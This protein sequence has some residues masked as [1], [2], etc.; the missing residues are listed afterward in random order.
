MYDES[1]DR[2]VIYYTS[3]DNGTLGM[4]DVEDCGFALFYEDETCQHRVMAENLNEP[5]ALAI[6][7]ERG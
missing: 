7:Q 5:R 4:L 6:D 3:Y 1:Q 2:S